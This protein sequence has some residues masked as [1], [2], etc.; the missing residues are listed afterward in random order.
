MPPPSSSGTQSHFAL[1]LCPA[2]SIAVCSLFLAPGLNLILSIGLFLGL[3]FAYRELPRRWVS[4]DAQTGP[5]TAAE[6]EPQ[7]G[8]DVPFICFCTD[9][10]GG[11]A[12]FS[13][14]NVIFVLDIE[15]TLRQKASRDE[16]S[17][18]FGSP[19]L[20]F[21]KKPSS[22]RKFFGFAFAPGFIGAVH[23]SPSDAN[24]HRVL[25][26]ALL[27]HNHSDAG[28]PCNALPCCKTGLTCGLNNQICGTYFG[29]GASVREFSVLFGVRKIQQCMD[30]PP[31]LHTAFIV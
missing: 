7:S 6:Y 19:H 27:F 30:L 16:S 26:G 11:L 3:L 9:V 28:S 25:C 20:I 22:S 12:I 31:S 17:W 1:V 15:L 24:H 13:A 21:P 29:L 18:T 2:F 23:A 4:D 8:L 5:P 14:I 10:G